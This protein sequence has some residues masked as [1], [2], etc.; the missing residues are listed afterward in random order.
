MWPRLL[1]GVSFEFVVCKGGTDGVY[2]EAVNRRERVGSLF[3]GLFRTCVQRIHE[4]VQFRTARE[5]VMKT[6]LYVQATA[7]AW[8]D[9]VK[10]SARSEAVTN[11][12]C[13]CAFLVYERLLSVPA[14]A[15]IIDKTEETLGKKTPWDS[16]Y[17]LDALARFVGKTSV[18]ANADNA[19]WCLESVLDLILDNHA[20]AGEFSVRNLTGK[21][22]GNR[23]VFHLFLFKRDCMKHLLYTWLPTLKIHELDKS[24]IRDSLQ[25]FSDYRLRA[26]FTDD[27]TDLSWL[28][29]LTPAG[30]AT[31]HF[32]E[33]GR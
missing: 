32:V 23:G 15:A 7:Q 29:T 28:S 8:R 10:L 19:A 2:L 18:K 11:Y 6:S 20:S 9:N 1:R 21:G 12:M 24:M 22:I 13:E 14:L 31:L 17:K 27:G 26:G 4:L 5:R 16:A 3:D 30:R 25:S 33:A